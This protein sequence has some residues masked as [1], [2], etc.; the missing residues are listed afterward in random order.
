MI[1]GKNEWHTPFMK[2][3]LFNI[4]K[5]SLH[6]GPGIRT[7]VFFQGCPLACKWCSN[8]ESQ[9]T[10]P[11][12]RGD[13]PGSRLYSDSRLYSI[14]ETL[15]ICLQDR[16]FYEESGG[17]VTLSGGEA[18]TQS[19]FAAALL[20]GLRAEHIHTALETSGYARPA[21]FTEIAARADMLLFDIKHYDD[22]RHVEGTGVHN[23][24]I[25]ANLKAALD[26]NKKV[27]VR[28]PVIPAYNNSPEDARAFAALLTG[29]GIRQAQLLPFHQFG[30]KKYDLLN[31]P[32][33]LR[34]VPQ[35][36]RE[37]V[38]GFQAII[39]QAGIECFF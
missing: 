38:E 17:G 25:L 2:G 35:L 37:D 11:A 10:E 8:P 31:I 12:L 1:K 6:D 16:L 19:A 39:A 23:G 14:E 13:G 7:V 30:E 5:F 22:R 28:L 3:L 21:V 27:I 20:D 32:Y 9:R 18:L 24:P 29:M 33:T 36:H 34:G 26:T 15:Q 4:Q